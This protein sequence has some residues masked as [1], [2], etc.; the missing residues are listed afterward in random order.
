V[1][2]RGLPGQHLSKL[3]APVLALGAATLALGAA[4][5]QEAVPLRQPLDPPQSQLLLAPADQESGPALLGMRGTTSEPAGA[6]A[7]RLAVRQV[8]NRARLLTRLPVQG[9]FRPETLPLEPGREA[10]PLADPVLPAPLL[11]PRRR[12]AEADPYAQVGT[13]IGNIRIF[14]A[15]QEDIG[16][17]TNPNRDSR[18]SGRRKGSILLRPEGELR[19]QSDWSR[20]ELTAHLRGAYHEYLD[21]QGADR[22]EASGRVNLRV[23]ATRDTRIDLEG[24]YFLDTQ[25]PGSPE[26]NAPVA[27]RPLVQTGGGSLGVTQRFN[28]LSLGLRG[29]V[30]RTTYEDARLPDGVILDQSDRDVTQY[31]ARLR[32]GYELK[33]G[34][35]PFVEGIVDTRD[36]DRTVDDAGFRRSSD[37]LGARAGST[38]EITRKLTG[39]A[40]GGYMERRYDDERLPDLRGPLVE[41]SIIWAATP[42]TT[43]RLRGTTQ[44]ADTSLADSSG[45][46]VSRATLEVQH[47][48][49]RNLSLIGSVTVSQADY[50]GIFL[51]EEGLAASLKLDYR[52]T[53]SV[54]LR[55]SFTHERLRS[56]DPG[57]DYTA[58]VYLV[59]LRFQP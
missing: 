59:G 28:R 25:R 37:G 44:I 7:T 20:H 54:A 11:R 24:R 58:N 53:R 45:A 26:L 50:R 31:E 32:A 22:P 51:R 42:L 48:L 52:L 16:Y 47:D 8:R 2:H 56:T 30:D 14:P 6:R 18:A 23:D 43:V 19:L 33:P 13:R 46:L 1:E 4:G 5:A 36:Y 9:R 39:E 17:D 29:N 27:E 57:D 55:A 34:L 15:V 3:S 40:S 21:V 10:Q 41:G 12:A 49:R 35:T 38:F